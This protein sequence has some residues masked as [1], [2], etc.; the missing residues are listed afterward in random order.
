MTP[1]TFLGPS[2]R[3][4]SDPRIQGLESVLVELLLLLALRLKVPELGSRLATRL[5]PTRPARKM[6]TW[7][8]RRQ[9]ESG[10]TRR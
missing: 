3:V 6:P 7:V 8:C 10:E 4:M 1:K 9:Q 2:N 5:K